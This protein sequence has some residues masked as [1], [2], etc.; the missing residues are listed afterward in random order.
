MMQLKCLSCVENQTCIERS[1][2]EKMKMVDTESRWLFN[3]GEIH[4]FLQEIK[5]AEFDC[6][7]RLAMHACYAALFN[8]LSISVSMK[9]AIFLQWLKFRFFNLRSACQWQT[10]LPN[11][12]L[13]Y[14]ILYPK[15]KDQPS[16]LVIIWG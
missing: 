4:S 10:V 7:T 11:G 6:L 16:R 2:E 9:T 1:N 14:F 3:K 5:L 12:N 8:N 13:L 15:V